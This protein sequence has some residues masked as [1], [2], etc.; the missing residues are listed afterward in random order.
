[1][2][3]FIDGVA[4]LNHSGEVCYFDSLSSEILELVPEDAYGKTL[5]SLLPYEAIEG[6]WND[7]QAEQTY[8]SCDLVSTWTEKQKD[9]S[10]SMAPYTLPP[11]VKGFVVL[12][13]DLTAVK[14]LETMQRDFITNISHELRT[15]LTSIKMAAESL[16]LGAINDQR[17]KQKFLSNIQRESDRLTRL[18]NELL[19][20]SNVQDARAMLNMSS[21]DPVR[22]FQDVTITMEH[23]AD[24]NDLQLVSDFPAILPTLK[25]DRDRINQVLINLIDNAIKCNKPN[26]TV[27]LHA[28]QNDNHLVIKVIDTGIGIP[29]IDRNRIFNR[30]FRVD[31]SRSRVTGGTGLGLS[32]VKDIIEAHD[33][34]IDVESTLNVGTTFTISLP[35]STS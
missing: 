26:G 30:F 14:R 5:I 7:V 25:A 12:F 19:V 35:I 21:F 11:D 8:Q 23:H 13:R 18:V 1:M 34:T 33:G 17:L 6:L 31:K 15:P 29:N 4:L 32:I 2:T 22:L 20:L 16:Q 27:T 28:H 9:M 3:N 10:I 24:L